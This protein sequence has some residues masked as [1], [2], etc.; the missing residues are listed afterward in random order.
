MDMQIERRSDGVVKVELA[1]RFDAPG[2]EQIGTRFTAAAGG[3][4]GLR[5]IVDL[6]GVEFLASMGMRLLISSA[7]AQH[8]RGGRLAL[9]GAPPLVAEVLEQAALDQ[10][11][12]IVP[13][14]A[15]ALAQMAN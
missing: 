8:G 12:P 9:F 15:E 10:I 2:A 4:A 1:G 11:I 5:V 13:T 3:A 7:R 14:E 6:S